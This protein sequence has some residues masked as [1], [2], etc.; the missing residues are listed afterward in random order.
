MIQ[1]GS[2][3]AHSAA[4]VQRVKGHLRF[5]LVCCQVE[6]SADWLPIE[7]TRLLCRVRGYQR[8]RRGSSPPALISPAIAPL[9]QG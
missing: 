7:R 9:T 4:G 3:A 6:G 1:R 5:L 2:R 8:I